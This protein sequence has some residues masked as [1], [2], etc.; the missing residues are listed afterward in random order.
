MPLRPP[1][2]PAR[3][4]SPSPLHTQPLVA[5][6]RTRREGSRW[7]RHR[8]RSRCGAASGLRAGIGAGCASAD[9]DDALEMAGN[10]V[11]EPE[12]VTISEIGRVCP[13]TRM[14]FA[15]T[16]PTVGR[17]RGRPRPAGR[18]GG[19][20]RG[21]PR[22][23]HRRPRRFQGALRGRS[24]R[25]SRPSIRR[26]RQGRPG[27][28]LGGRDRAAEHPGRHA[29]G[30]AARGAAAG[31]AAR[32]GP[33]RRQPRAACSTAPVRCV[34]GGDATVPEISAA[35]IV[36]KV[37][38]DALMCRLALRHP[39]YGWER[40]A[41][42]PTREHLAALARL[43]L[44]RH[45]R[46]GFA[47]CATMVA[48][49]A[50]R[51]AACLTQVSAAAEHR[52]PE[53]IAGKE[54]LRTVAGRE[55]QQQKGAAGPGGETAGQAQLMPGADPVLAP[56]RGVPSASEKKWISAAASSVDALAVV[57]LQ[58]GRR[59]HGTAEPAI[60]VDP[61]RAQRAGPTAG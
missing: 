57:E 28:G 1:A 47:P 21:H 40:N 46:R 22:S 25:S 3:A 42:Y 34:V 26:A 20:G 55:Y 14:A 35:S 32:P 56:P 23:A 15:V 12:H 41:G 38:R 17:R 43:G 31:R 29:A 37:A 6:P 50:G 61:R 58:Q 5:H 36:A 16:G 48:V 10:N 24:A 54:A 9:P 2:M 30:H 27:G 49:A 39:G 52:R 13:V 33:G 11:G 60:A 44:N 45:H 19:G 51:A 4:S 7:R 18:A 59:G 53:R 8:L